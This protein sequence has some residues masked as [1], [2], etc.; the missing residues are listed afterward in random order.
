MAFDRHQA[1]GGQDDGE[2]QAERYSWTENPRRSPGQHAKQEQRS[3]RQEQTQALAGT[4]SQGELTYGCQQRR[5]G[6]QAAAGRLQFPAVQCV[7]ARPEHRGDGTGEGY[8]LKTRVLSDGRPEGQHQRQR[9]TDDE[10]AADQLAPQDVVRLQEGR[11]GT[12]WPTRD[13][14]VHLGI[15]HRTGVSVNGPRHNPTRPRV[16]QEDGSQG[17]RFTQLLQTTIPESSPQ[18]KLPD[19]TIG[20]VLL[21]RT[22][23]ITVPHHLKDE[24]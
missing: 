11:E 4:Q 3:A 5:D 8:D 12:P 24:G 7:E 10:Q 18:A 14:I 13:R 22:N 20:V 19:W 2:G 6:Q 21:F 15:V 23:V 17:L 16:R 1:R 9:T